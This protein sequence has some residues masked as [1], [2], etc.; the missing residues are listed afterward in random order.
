MRT[1]RHPPDR[2]IVSREHDERALRRRPDIERPDQP[3]HPGR[4]DYRRAVFVPVV[5]EGFVGGEGA[6][7]CGARGV[8]CGYLGG[9]LGAVDGEG[10]DEVVGG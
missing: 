2:I 4:R 3:I 6:C 8:G 7:P 1:P 5:R 9:G 10:E